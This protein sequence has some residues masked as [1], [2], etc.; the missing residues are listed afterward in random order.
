MWACQVWYIAFTL[1]TDKTVLTV[2]QPD[3]QSVLVQRVG[4]GPRAA[5]LASAAAAWPWAMGWDRN[6][7]VSTGAVS[8]KLQST[9]LGLCP[10]ADSF[11]TASVCVSGTLTAT[12]WLYTG[13]AAWSLMRFRL[14]DDSRENGWSIGALPLNM[15]AAS[16]LST[17]ACRAQ[18][19]PQ[20][21][22]HVKMMRR[23]TTAAACITNTMC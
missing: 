23:D 13:C 10:G 14:I 6:H 9:E 3:S 16:R 2:S 7:L 17:P 11:L 4:C 1:N 8:V 22:V 12:E 15:H 21:K 20:A 5:A 18:L 19:G